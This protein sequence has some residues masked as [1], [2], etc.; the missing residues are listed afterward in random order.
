VQ[1]EVRNN[2][3]RKDFGEW[4]KKEYKDNGEIKYALIRYEE[5]TVMITSPQWYKCM[6]EN[7]VVPGTISIRKDMIRTYKTDNNGNRIQGADGQYEL[8]ETGRWGWTLI[9]A[10]SFDQIEAESTMEARIEALEVKKEIIVTTEKV[11]LSKLMKEINKNMHQS[12]L[13]AS[14]AKELLRMN[15][16]DGDDEDI[17]DEENG[18]GTAN[19]PVGTDGSVL[20]ITADGNINPQTGA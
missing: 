13:A 11:E 3:S 7:T 20:A 16:D 8:V 10:N 19:V 17:D 12:R 9:G 15:D 4:L 1:V 2:L 14:K 18:N 5:G 6:D